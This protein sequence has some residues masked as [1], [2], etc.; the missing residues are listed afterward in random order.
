[1]TSGH[2]P[3]YPYVVVPRLPEG[4]SVD[5]EAW[6]PGVGPLE[7]ELGPGRGAFLIQRCEAEP[8]VR[9]LGIEIRRKWARIVDERL[10][11]RGF[12]ARARVVCHDAKHALR[13]LVPD[14]C[15]ARVFF[16][17]PDP[18]WK[19]RHQKRLLLVDDVADEVCR[20]LGDD[21]ELYV[22]TDVPERAD[23]YERLLQL[24]P[25]LSPHGDDGA[26]CRLSHNPY[27]AQSNRERR[28][29]QDGLPIYRL[30]FRRHAR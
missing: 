1:M 11:R 24:R 2:R 4:D 6:L 25:E 30:R 9:M 19:K 20:L 28:A 3:D 10:A 22:Q 18:W 27:Q 7:L 16:H 5:L 26:G 21:G 13:R 29:T 12:G 23:Q 17:F 14:G 8:A 15:L